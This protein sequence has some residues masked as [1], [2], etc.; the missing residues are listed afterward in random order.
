[1]ARAGFDNHLAGF[2]RD[3]QRKPWSI[4]CSYQLSELDTVNIDRDFPHV[5]RQ[6]IDAVSVKV[7]TDFHCA[8]PP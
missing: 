4:N 2:L 8:S 5:Q 1:M 3:T 7:Q 6:H